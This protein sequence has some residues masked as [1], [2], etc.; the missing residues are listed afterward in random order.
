MAKRDFAHRSVSKFLGSRPG[1]AAQIFS[2]RRP[3]GAACRAE[4]HIENARDVFG[5][6]DGGR[7]MAKAIVVR[8]LAAVA[9]DDLGFVDFTQLLFRCGLVFAD[10]GMVLARELTVREFDRRLARAARNAERFVIIP[11][12]GA[13]LP[14]LPLRAASSAT[15]VYH[16]TI[17]YRLLSRMSTAIVTTICSSES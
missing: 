17:T 15:A 13:D 9:Q 10:V 16:F 4:E 6:A 11:G 1:V 2:G 5:A 3:C 14:A 12:D 7:R 8:A